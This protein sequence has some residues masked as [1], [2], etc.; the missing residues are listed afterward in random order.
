MRE[1]LVAT[2]CNRVDAAEVVERHRVVRHALELGAQE[3]RGLVV[4]LLFLQPIGAAGCVP[5]APDADETAELGDRLGIVLD[6]QVADPVERV[7]RLG[8]R[9][10]ALDDDRRGLLA[11]RVPA[12]GLPRLERGDEALDERADGLLERARHLLDD[13][14]AREDVPLD[15]EARADAVP[16]PRETLAAGKGRR[17]TVCGNGAELPGLPALV[18]SQ[19]SPERFVG[20]RAAGELLEDARPVRGDARRLGRDRADACARPRHDGADGEVLRL[21][22]AA[23]LARLQV[24]GDDREGAGYDVDRWR[25]R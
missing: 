20:L 23:D 8:R 12:G 21:D 18:V 3:R 17:A 24:G 19:H 16:G 11:A 22:G 7:A 13:R 5:R 2:A 10:R 25:S 15:G 4:T 9:A 14:L 1:R 6:A